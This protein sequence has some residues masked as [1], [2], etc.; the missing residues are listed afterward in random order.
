LLPL[1]L[2]VLVLALV[3]AFSRATFRVSAGGDLR[4]A[5]GLAARML[6]AQKAPLID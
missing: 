2:L 6:R 4:A 1:P 3:L 5:A